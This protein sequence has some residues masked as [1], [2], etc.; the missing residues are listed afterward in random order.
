MDRPVTSVDIKDE[1]Y[2][3]KHKETTAPTPPPKKKK[4]NKKQKT[5][6]SLHLE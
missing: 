5:V 1:D 3:K 4:K 6:H 2:N